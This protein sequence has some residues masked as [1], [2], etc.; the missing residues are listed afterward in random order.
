SKKTSLR[1]LSHCHSISG[2]IATLFIVLIAAALIF[3]L[4]TVNIGQLIDTSTKLS[5]AVDSG[6]LYLGSELATKTKIM[7]DSLAEDEDDPPRYRT[8]H[9][10]GWVFT[11]LSLTGVGWFLGKIIQGALNAR[12]QG[13]S[14]WS[15]GFSGF[16]EGLEAAAAVAGGFIAGGPVGA[17]IAGGAVMVN[18]V[19]AERN[20]N[21]VMSSLVKGMHDLSEEERIREQVFLKVLSQVVDDP[22]QVSD[23]NDIDDD[24]DTTEKILQFESWWDQRI[25]SLASQSDFDELEGDAQEFVEGP[26][27]EFRQYCA[28]T[29]TIEY[30]SEDYTPPDGSELFSEMSGLEG[31]SIIGQ[32]R[33]RHYS[34]WFA[35]QTSRPLEGYPEITEGIIGSLFA[36]QEV[37]GTD[38]EFIAFL[39]QLDDAQYDNG[40]DITIPFWSPGPDKE[41]LVSL[42]TEC[43]EDCIPPASFDAVDQSIGFLHDIIYFADRTHHEERNWGTGFVR[44]QFYREVKNALYRSGRASEG[45]ANDYYDELGDMVN[46][47]LWQ[48]QGVLQWKQDI[49]L[50]RQQLPQCGYGETEAEACVAC[51]EGHTCARTCV[52]NPPCQDGAFGSMDT[53]TDDEFF[54]MN[55]ALQAFI[56]R[57]NTLRDLIAVMAGSSE[58]T[59][60]INSVTYDWNDTRGYHRVVV[61]I[62]DF[63]V[64]DIRKRSRNWGTRKCW[65]IDPPSAESWVRVTRSDSAN[66]RMGLLGKWNPFD[67]DGDGLLTL[68][69]TAKVRHGAWGDHD[70][71]RY[72]RVELI[73]DTSE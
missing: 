47:N 55:N 46:G 3:I 70:V 35:Q 66:V 8:C 56:D 45:A 2:Q 26:L 53:D 68:S 51:E 73:S 33:E 62:N 7:G 44:R 16:L 48:T 61:E 5:N 30:T 11:A 27:Q 9:W 52:A 50:I 21:N 58:R 59:G 20:L 28:G 39:R 25:E 60:S 49:N 42:M 63:A 38:G 1:N 23:T 40:Q 37:E 18:D 57:V 12:E 34:E 31:A 6:A 72:F 71:I 64:P 43:D 15:G 14:M 69:R 29:Q 54:E 17:V 32:Q 24:E 4:V 36:R 13:K 10:G 65:S 41:A 22:T 19:L 67:L